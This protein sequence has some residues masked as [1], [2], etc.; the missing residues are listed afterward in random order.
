M[1]SSIKVAKGVIAAKLWVLSIPPPNDK[2][3]KHSDN[4]QTQTDADTM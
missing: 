4:G 1:P 3:L 2:G